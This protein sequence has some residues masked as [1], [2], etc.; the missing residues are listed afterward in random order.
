MIWFWNTF[1][2]QTVWVRTI[3]IVGFSRRFVD[4]FCT[5]L[6]DV[7]DVWFGKTQAGTCISGEQRACPGKWAV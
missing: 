2:S 4:T 7:Q 3:N 5:G 1:G 6:D